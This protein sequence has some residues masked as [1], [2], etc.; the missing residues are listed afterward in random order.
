V[1]KALVLQHDLV[2]FAKEDNML[3]NRSPLLNTSL[4]L[5]FGDSKP[6]LSDKFG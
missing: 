1:Q 3:G 4:Q 6:Y 5:M 2:Q